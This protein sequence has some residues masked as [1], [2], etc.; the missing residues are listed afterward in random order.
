M[1]PES[2]APEIDPLDSYLSEETKEI[3]RFGPGAGHRYEAAIMERKMAGDRAAKDIEDPEDPFVTVVSRRGGVPNHHGTPMRDGAA[4]LLPRS[5]AQLARTLLNVT[6]AAL[7]AKE[8]AA[9]EAA[10][11]AAWHGLS[12]EAR[13]DALL[14]RVERL[15]ERR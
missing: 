12:L 4:F 8:D 6:C 10:K 2:P 5:Q 11:E 9:Q 14:A 15:E 3:L 1:A 13:L 7:D